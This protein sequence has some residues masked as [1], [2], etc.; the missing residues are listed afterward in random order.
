MGAEEATCSSG[1]RGNRSCRAIEAFATPAPIPGALEA[2]SAC[3]R[4][5]AIVM[6]AGGGIVVAATD[7]DVAAADAAAALVGV[8]AVGVGD[9]L[10]GDA[11]AAIEQFLQGRR[12]R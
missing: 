6:V 1:W 10:A 11:D 12:C 8:V 5:A 9:I 3:R 4:Q 2:H 7:V